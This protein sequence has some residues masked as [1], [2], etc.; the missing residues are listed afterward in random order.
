MINRKGAFSIRSQDACRAAPF[1]RVEGTLTRLPMEAEMS[2]FETYSASAR[3]ARTRSF[4][5]FG[6]AAFAIVVARFKVWKNRRSVARL[7]EWDAHM[8]ADIGLTE[9]DV[10]SALATR[11]DED[12][13]TQL[14]MRSL[15][16]RYASQ[17]QARD[18]MAHAALLSVG[19]AQYRRKP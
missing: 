7:L 6:A 9:G 14:Q 4:A 19:S 5:A 13:S 1:E 8:L 18:R 15:E 16:R 10:Y 11:A 12:A 17:A 2:T 3:P